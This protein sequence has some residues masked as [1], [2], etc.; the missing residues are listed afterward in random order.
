MTQIKWHVGYMYLNSDALRR[1]AGTEHNEA[2]TKSTDAHSVSVHSVSHPYSLL[3]IH[4]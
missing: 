4:I 1:N 2:K 3:L